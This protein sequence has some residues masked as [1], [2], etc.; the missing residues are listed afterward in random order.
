MKTAICRIWNLSM[1]SICILIFRLSKKISACFRQY[2]RNQRH[3]TQKPFFKGCLTTYLNLY[4]IDFTIQ[5]MYRTMLWCSISTA[6]QQ[7]LRNG[8]RMVVKK[9]LRTFLQSFTFVSTE[10][11]DQFQFVK[12]V[13][14]VSL[15]VPWFHFQVKPNE[16]I[17]NCIIII[18]ILQKVLK[19]YCFRT[20]FCLSVG[21]EKGFSQEFPG[22]ARK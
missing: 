10:E 5:G 3:L 18:N 11:S 15:S 6:L 21:K 9:A 1:R 8:W 17:W 22:K 7:S 12:M 20:F 13:G 19:S 14:M 16:T 4:W 2:C